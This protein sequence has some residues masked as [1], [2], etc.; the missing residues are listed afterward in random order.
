[1]LPAGRQVPL[2]IA[3][4]AFHDFG[5][6]EESLASFGEVIACRPSLEELAPEVIL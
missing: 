3:D 6:V 5:L 1:L 2:N 4:R